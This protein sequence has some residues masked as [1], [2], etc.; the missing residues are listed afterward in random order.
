M[1]TSA[2]RT[3]VPFLDLR[4]SHEPI[5]EALLSEIDRL[6]DSDAFT[7][8]VQVG[9]FEEAFAARCGTARCVG[10]ASGLDALRLGL[11]AAGIRPGDEV[12][13][14]AMT[15]I[16]TAEAVTQAGG[17]PVFV[18]ISESDYGIDAAAAEAAITDSTAFIL[19]VHLYG[20]LADMRALVEVAQRHELAI[21][22][23]A[24]QAHDAERDGLRAGTVGVAAAFSFYP[25]KNLGAMGDAGALVT[26]DHELADTAV[27]LREHGQREK[28]LHELEGYTA[29][30]DTIQALVLLLKLPFLDGW[31][32]SRSHAAAFYFEALEG[33]GD[34][35]LPPVP[36][37][38][39]PVWHRYVIRTRDPQ[40]LASFLR[41][42]GIDTARNYPQPL[43]LVPAYSGLRSA[44]DQ[45]PV[46]E[47]LAAEA[48]SLPLYPG[49]DENQLEQVAVAIAA[50]FR[51]VER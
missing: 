21:L 18:D 47:R 3:V 35:R 34:L 20:Q 16:A 11:M 29:R 40:G 9:T 10:M 15:F 19:P 38:S 31:N 17:V 37:G 41:D 36:P 30:L 50:Y 49:L 27:A 22:D 12:I 51:A 43:H 23:D 4:P 45:F 1:S 42:R 24:C 14:P 6:I 7:N 13:V 2:T 32:V 26:N 25:G 33:L 8:G 28:Y 46:A 39:S 48:L 44:R 5:R